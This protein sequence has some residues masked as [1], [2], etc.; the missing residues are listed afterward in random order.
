LPLGSVASYH[1]LGA[2]DGVL[3]ARGGTRVRGGI[4]VVVALCAL[5]WP[6]GSG[7]GWAAPPISA[8]LVTPVAPEAPVPVVTPPPLRAPDPAVFELITMTRDAG[9]AHSVSAGTAFFIDANGTALTNSHVVY[10]AFTEP[11]RYRLLAII[12]AEF[13]SASIVCASVLAEASVNRLAPAPLGRDIAE[14]RVMPSAFEFVRIRDPRAG[15]TYVAHRGPVPRFAALP[16]GHAPAVGEVVRIVGYGESET[17]EVADVQWT[18]TGM[19]SDISTAQD[20]TPVF[21]VESQ[22]RPRPGNSGSPVLDDQGYVIGMYTWN[23]AES[24][25]AG[26]AIAG[27]ALARACP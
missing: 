11:A 4:A 23:V 21:G 25:T 18:T 1:R 7:A 3:A 6:W 14:I 19:V 8:V 17:P 10:A 27:P 9:G 2:G 26:L 13:Y 15:V 22:H 12:G 5:A 24:A 16:L 20:G